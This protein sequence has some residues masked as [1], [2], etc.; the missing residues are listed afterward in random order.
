MGRLCVWCKHCIAPHEPCARGQ[1]GGAS[2]AVGRAP[3]A[4]PNPAQHV[5][6]LLSSKSHVHA[7]ASKNCLPAMLSQ[8]RTKGG[9]WPIELMC[10]RRPR[11]EGGRLMAIVLVRSKEAVDQLPT[12]DPK[13]GISKRTSG[14]PSQT[15][16]R[17]AAAAQ[18]LTPSRPRKQSP[19][20]QHKPT[21][22]LSCSCPAP[23]MR[24]P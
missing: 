10:I 18:M 23:G 9:A 21:K 6:G 5:C 2:A 17:L 16:R 13:Q 7:S 14:P 22:Q 24:G 3:A 20:Q 1:A 19:D 15:S 12:P 8:L 11:P 4:V